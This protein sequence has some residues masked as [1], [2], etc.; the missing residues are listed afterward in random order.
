M[1]LF[2]DLPIYDIPQS[3]PS[4]SYG[5]PDG[6][7]WI[8]LSDPEAKDPSLQALLSKI[9]Q[10][11]G[12]TEDRDTYQLIVGQRPFYLYPLLNQH[13]EFKTILSFGINPK[14]LGMAV[15]YS[16]YNLFQLKGHQFLFSDSLSEIES[17]LSKKRL[18]W[19]SLKK[20][21]Q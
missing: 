10:A 14:A 18:L 16:I 19:E 17:N 21:N 6:K 11:I 2:K 1:T 12:V 20:L 7:F 13:R 5:S 8:V 15:S 9:L 3:A 4:G